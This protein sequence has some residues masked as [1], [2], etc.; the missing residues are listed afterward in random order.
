MFLF[1]G[2]CGAHEL[3]L[4]VGDWGYGDLLILFFRAVEGGPS[5][6]VISSASGYLDISLGSGTF[7]AD[8]GS[9]EG[10][11][12]GGGVSQGWGRDEKLCWL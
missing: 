3:A 9:E 2:R 4:V 8:E 6:V 10:F 11:G 7:L 5:S 12:S 1:F